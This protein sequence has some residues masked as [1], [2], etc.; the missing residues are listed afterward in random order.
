MTF[1]AKHEGRVAPQW[2]MVAAAMLAALPLSACGDDDDDDDLPA[3][4]DASTTRDAATGM[5]DASTTRDAATGMRDAST[6]R[7][8][9]SDRDADPG[10]DEDGG[11]AFGFDGRHV[12]RH[13]TFGDERFWTDELSMHEVIASAV[14]PMTALAVGLKVDADALP[15]GILATADL[16]DPATTVALIGLGAVVGIEG[17]VDDAGDLTSVGITCALCHS[18][19]DDSVMEGIGKRLD[20]YANRDL[21]PGKI[22]SLSPAF[23]GNAAALAVLTSWGPGRY[24]ARWN[25]DGINAPVLIPPIYGL[26]DVALETYTGDGPISYWNAYVAVTQMGGQGQ[27]FDPRI[28]VAVIRMPDEVTPKLPALYDYQIALAAP[29]PA[30]AS[31]DAAAAARGELLFEGDAQCGSCHSGPQ[32]T[33]AADRLHDPAETGMEA[34]AAE[35]SATGK[36]RTTPLRALAQHPPYFHDG[37]AMTLAAVVDHYDAELTLALDAGQKADLVEYLKSL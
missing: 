7:D 33:D 3:G 16:T 19:V 35:R 25:Q 37:S 4:R 15:E 2:C 27:F 13:D 32:Y 26:R 23:E 24:D 17:E 12:F 6:T 21:D 22:I 31:F 34:V 9:A 1:D 29:E 5:R 10:E 8:A 20:G 11:G 36:Y 18:D 14:D 28:G 30:A